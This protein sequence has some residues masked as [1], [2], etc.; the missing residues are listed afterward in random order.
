MTKPKKMPKIKTVMTA[1]PHSVIKA[2]SIQ[3]A[4]KFMRQHHLHHLPVTE[5]DQVIGIISDRDIKLL[6]GPDFDYPSEK[7]LTVEDAYM[8]NAYIVDLSTPL[9]L[10]LE[11]MA[12]RHIGSAIVTRK[13]KLAGVFTHEDVCKSFA[14][15]LREQFPE[16]GGNDAA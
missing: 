4:Q 5:G 11:N 7:E 2:T 6:L 15:H 1:F 16:N 14:S 3:N 12:K 10:V 13:K 9:D 8:P